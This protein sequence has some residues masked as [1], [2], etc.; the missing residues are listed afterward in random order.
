MKSLRQ[1]I[2][3]VSKLIQAKRPLGCPECGW[4]EGRPIEATIE[5]SNEHR[6]TRDPSRRRPE[7]SCATCGFPRVMR[8]EF[9]DRG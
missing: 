1:R 9:D 4:Y 2:D 8:I 3:V 6:S 5:F 7:D